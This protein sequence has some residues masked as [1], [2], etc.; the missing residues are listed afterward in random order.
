MTRPV[1]LPTEYSD[2]SAWSAKKSP[3]TL[4]TSKASCAS[5][6]RS[7]CNVRLQSSYGL[8]TAADCNHTGAYRQRHISIASLLDAA[9]LKLHMPSF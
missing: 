7:S 3:L 6:S 4:N 5:C 9:A 8:L 1:D 2:S